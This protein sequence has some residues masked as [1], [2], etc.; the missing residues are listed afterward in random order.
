MTILEGSCI[1]SQS[2]F[3]IVVRIGMWLMPETGHQ[4]YA[5][6]FPREEDFPEIVEII[7]PL[8][9]QSVLGNVPQLRH[10]FQ[11]LA[12]TARPKSDIY[13]GTGPIPREVIR[14]HAKKLP[15]GDVSWVFYGTQ[16]GDKATIAA[17][18]DAI[19]TAF[20]QIPG[21]KMVFPEGVPAEHYLHSRIDVCS[22]VPVLRERDWLAWVP[23]AAR[24]S[25]SARSCR[26][27]GATR[28]RRTASSRGCTTGTASI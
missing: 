19:R 10:I 12:T 13:S 11:E 28:R 16:Y 5:I 4:S 24:T 18:L 22:G 27:G 14:E 3:G 26:R 17:Q 1:F 15:L 7:R 6:T 2:N 23:N 8:A 21:A 20:S 9:Q 25:S